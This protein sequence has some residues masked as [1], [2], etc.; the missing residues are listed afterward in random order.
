MAGNGLV[1]VEGTVAG[2]TSFD[3]DASG[4]MVDQRWNKCSYE[5]K[6]ILNDWRDNLQDGVEFV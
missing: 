2:H 4:I 5:G 1:Q 6:T 3:A